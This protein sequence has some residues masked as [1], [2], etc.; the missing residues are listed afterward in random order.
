MGDLLL[1][2][3]TDTPGY[4]ADALDEIRVYRELLAEGLVFSSN[5]NNNGTNDT[6][7]FVVDW[8]E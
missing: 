5:R 7:L 1:K 3:I 8:I 2:K 4:D 6:N